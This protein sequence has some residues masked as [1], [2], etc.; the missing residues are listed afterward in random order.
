MEILHRE[1]PV[2]GLP[3]TC[4]VRDYSVFTGC[5][6]QACLK[7]SAL[8]ISGNFLWSGFEQKMSTDNFIAFIIKNIG[9]ILKNFACFKSFLKTILQVVAKKPSIHPTKN[10]NPNY[11]DGKWYVKYFSLFFSMHCRLH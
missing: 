1:N 11:F 5:I 10:R 6:V 3:C 2:L 7:L 4:P 9:D 8:L